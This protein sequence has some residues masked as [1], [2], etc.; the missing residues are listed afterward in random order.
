MAKKCEVCLGTGKHEGMFCACSEGKL[1]KVRQQAE[2]RAE[3]LAQEERSKMAQE[4]RKRIIKVR[5]V[6]SA[7]LTPKEDHPSTLNKPFQ[8]GDWVTLDGKNVHP[9]YRGVKA[10]I[11]EIGG[12]SALIQTVNA[13]KNGVFE[14]HEWVYIESLVAAPIETVNG[15]ENFLIDLALH[16]N[17]EQ[18]FKELT[19]KKVKGR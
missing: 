9:K 13:R 2:E 6:E 5:K 1:M 19:N 12:N 11:E 3:Q 15:I 17:D 8:K 4:E 16:T 14:K 10:Y 18:W 7:P